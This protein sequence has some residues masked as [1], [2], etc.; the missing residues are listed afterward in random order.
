MKQTVA[1]FNFTIDSSAFQFP[2]LLCADGA[3]LTGDAV[4]GLLESQ[5]LMPVRWQTTLLRMA[6]EAQL[7]H[8]LD[9]GPGDAVA[10]LSMSALRGTG[11][12]VIPL[13][14]NRG[15]EAFF[16][17][18]DSPIP[19]PYSHYAPKTAKL[20]NGKVVV[21]NLYTRA[22]GESPVILPGMTPTTVDAPIVAAGANAGFT[23]GIGRGW[24]GYGGDFPDSRGGIERA[25]KARS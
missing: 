12:S 20:P 2:V 3:P 11:I 19:V 10:R 16:E 25:A 14:L 22:T 18:D 15:R 13:S 24:A 17:G 21:N 23:S 8:V 7:T 6:E 5:F 9:M 4:E 1:E